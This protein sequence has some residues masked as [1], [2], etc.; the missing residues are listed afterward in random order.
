[1]V[2]TVNTSYD[3]TRTIVRK[4]KSYNYAEFLAEIGEKVLL[5][6]YLQIRF[7]EEE[8]EFTVYEKSTLIRET[9]KLTAS[10]LLCVCLKKY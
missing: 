2:S 4:V 10:H 1:M 6:L 5:D 8:S 9:I 3:S 7:M